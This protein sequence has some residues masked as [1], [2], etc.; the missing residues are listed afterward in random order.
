MRETI[1]PTAQPVPRWRLELDCVRSFD[2][3]T[4][5]RFYQ[6]IQIGE[7]N[8]NLW[9]KVQDHSA[10][11]EHA[12]VSGFGI[13]LYENGE[14]IKIERDKRFCSLAWSFGKIQTEQL[15][16]SDLNQM[17]SFFARCPNSLGE[18]WS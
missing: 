4:D 17:F 1:K 15:S 14:K 9:R 5:F 3:Q 8:V 16:I 7:F 6:P 18:S 12:D 13:A 2:K 10:A 11:V